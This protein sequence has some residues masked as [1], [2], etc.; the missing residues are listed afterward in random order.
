MVARVNFKK[1]LVTI[2]NEENDTLYALNIL[3][4]LKTYIL[5]HQYVD[6]GKTL[7]ME[8]DSTLESGVLYFFFIYPFL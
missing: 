6:V 8:K 4:S 1:T 2:R 7:F 5:I 3:F